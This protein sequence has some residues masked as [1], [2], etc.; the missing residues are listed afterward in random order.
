MKKGRLIFFLIAIIMISLSISLSLYFPEI[1]NFYFM[2]S[3]LMIVFIFATF[4]KKKK[5]MQEIRNIIFDYFNYCDVNKYINEIEKFYKSCI[6]FTKPQKMSFKL[7]LVHG[8]I[9]A[10]D[11]ETAEKLLLEIDKYSNKFSQVTKFIY[12]KTWCDYFFYTH[13]DEKMKYTIEKIKTLI[14]S[15]KNMNIRVSCNLSYQIIVSEYMLISQNGN[16]KFVKDVL[17]QRLKFENQN[18]SR[19]MIKYLIGILC[20]KEKMYEQGITMLTEVSKHHDSLYVSKNSLKL[21]NQYN[22]IISNKE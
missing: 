14:T 9:D 20:L 4:Y 8:Y 15:I 16:Y 19:L 2:N 18:K 6:F 5:E 21:I 3:L 22:D 1:P 13:K 7:Y 10:G 17:Y 12:L 11:F